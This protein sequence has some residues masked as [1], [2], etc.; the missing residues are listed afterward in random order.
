MVKN[1]TDK[2]DKRGLALALLLIAVLV[3]GITIAYF[4]DE[5]TVTNTFTVGNVGLGLEEPGW[6]PENGE[7]LYPGEVIIKDP[8]VT[9][10]GDS[11]MRLIMTIEDEDGNIITGQS[12]V[13]KILQTLY[14]EITSGTLVP[15][16]SDDYTDAALATLVSGDKIKGFSGFNTSQYE[17]QAGKSSLGKYVYYYKNGSSYVFEDG[18]EAK[19]IT[20][21]V[22]PW[23]WDQDDLDLLGKYQ[24]TFRAEAIQTQGFIDE[25]VEDIATA[26][27]ALDT[28]LAP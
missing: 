6:D 27:A 19:F 24:V 22:I 17:Y 2:K 4:T 8:V 18:T 15:G 10:D 11:F 14:Y 25:G 13:E 3:I 21:V 28:A 16:T 23:D 26:F 9:A 7:N 5:D 1:M 12:R 20:H